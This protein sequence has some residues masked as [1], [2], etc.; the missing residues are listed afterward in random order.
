MTDMVLKTLQ[1]GGLWLIF[2][3]LGLLVMIVVLLITFIVRA[4]LTILLIAAAPVILMWHALPHTEGIARTWWKASR[5]GQSGRVFATD[6]ATES[7]GTSP[8]RS[9]PRSGPGR[10]W[11]CCGTPAS[12][13]RRCWS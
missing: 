3:G 8:T 11:K 9:R 1:G 13:S 2:I 4:M 5:A 6:L 12:G 7:N 10:R